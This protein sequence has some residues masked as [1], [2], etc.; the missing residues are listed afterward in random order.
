MNVAVTVLLAFIV[1]LAGAVPVAAPDH[2]AKELFAPGDP[3]RVTNVPAANVAVPAPVIP[4]GEL[5]MFP[6]PVPA[7]TTVSVYVVGATVVTGLM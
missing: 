1:M 7:L 5:V 2:P 4:A 3:V 6:L